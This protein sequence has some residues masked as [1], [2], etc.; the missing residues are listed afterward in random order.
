MYDLFTSAVL[1]FLLAPGV[2]ITLPPGASSHVAAF[3]HAVV[4]YLVQTYLPMYVPNWGIW[5][6]GAA[7]LAIKMLIARRQAAAAASSPL[8]GLTGARRR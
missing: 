7:V 4:F 8:S 5:I 6:A 3:V 2:V 1:F